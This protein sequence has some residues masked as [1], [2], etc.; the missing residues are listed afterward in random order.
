MGGLPR[1]VGP[2]FRRAAWPGLHFTVREVGPTFRGA[3]QALDQA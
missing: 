3:L 2:T 1:V